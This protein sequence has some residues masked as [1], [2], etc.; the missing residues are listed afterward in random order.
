MASDLDRA[1]DRIFYSRA[2]DL[3]NTTTPSISIRRSFG[4][5]INTTS[6]QSSINRIDQILQQT[7]RPSLIE[8]L[9]KH[10]KLSRFT[11]LI[12]KSNYSR[13]LNS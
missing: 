6:I 2:L 11:E 9:H 5:L 7:R 3:L 12:L 10:A 8:H 13:I 4:P 1:S